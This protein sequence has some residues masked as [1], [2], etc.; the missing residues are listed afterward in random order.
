MAL[1]AILESYIH[2]V[3]IMVTLPLGLV[4]VILSL[5]LTGATL[6]IFSMMAM[7]M[8]VGIVV[9]NGILLLDYIHVLR[10]RGTEI[11]EAILKACSERLRPIIMMNL[12]V[13]LGMLPLAL[14]LGEGSE[15]RSPMAIVSIGGIITSTIFTVF[16]I[17]VIYLSFEKIKL[18][19]A[20]KV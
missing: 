15:T 16:L 7:V 20:K 13:A 17:P 2:P 5:L 14:G 4:G 10:E 19:S 3:T 8:L 1:A 6:S 11:I 9:N 12:A 18:R